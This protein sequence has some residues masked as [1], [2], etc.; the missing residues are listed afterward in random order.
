M[1]LSCFTW[2]SAGCQEEI[3]WIDSTNSSKK[4]VF[5]FKVRKRNM[6][7]SQMK[8]FRFH[9]HTW[10]LF[11]GCQKH[12][13]QATRKKYKHH[14]PLQGHLSCHGRIQL[15]KCWLQAVN[16]L[17]FPDLHELLAEEEDFCECTCVRRTKYCLI[18]EIRGSLGSGDDGGGGSGGGGSGGGDPCELFWCVDLCIYTYTTQENIIVLSGLPCW[19]VY[20]Q[21]YRCH[22][23]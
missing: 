19:G 12:N 3:W 13:F 4:R 11:W 6:A 2:K 15:G 14:C 21:F 7:V 10:F 8:H 18:S 22:L 5:F 9:W 16:F 17:S 20:A 23:G 1:K